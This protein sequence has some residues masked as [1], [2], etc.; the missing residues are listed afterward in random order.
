MAKKLAIRKPRGKGFTYI[1]KASGETIKDIALKKWIKSLV[2][3][4]AWTKVKIDLNNKAKI[5]SWGRDAKGRK[6][7]I[8][9]QD[10]RAKKEK[11]K[12]DHIIEFAKRL[13]KTRKRIQKDLKRKGLDK[14]RVLACMVKLLDEAYFRAGSEKYAKENKTYGL[15]TIRSKHLKDFK[16]HLEFHYTGKSG[17]KQIRKVDDKMMVDIILKIDKLPGFE[18]FKYVDEKGKVVDVDRN[19]LNDYIHDVVGKGFTAKDFRTWAGTCLAAILLSEFEISKDKKLISKN[20]VKAV[21]G[22]AKHLGNTRAVAKSSYIDPRVIKHYN[23]GRTIKPYLR[24]VKNELTSEVTV[25]SSE[26]EKAV[27]KLIGLKI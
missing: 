2:I 14:K 15:T 24:E 11:E 20:I 7:Y 8:Y 9:N 17:K 22:V 23:A 5:H 10:F 13:P 21:D 1:Y 3:P 12:Y 19:C 16:D 26:G 25:R 4:P 18:I 6:Q 27:L